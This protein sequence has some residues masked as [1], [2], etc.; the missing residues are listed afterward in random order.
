LRERSTLLRLLAVVAAFALVGALAACGDDDDDSDDSAASGDTT[1]SGELRE[2]DYMLPYQDSMSFLGLM[3][4][5]DEGGCLEQDGIELNTLPSEGSDF[6]AQQLIAGNVDIGQTGADNILIA[7]ASGRELRGIAQVG[8]RGVFT[9][10]APEDSNVSSMEDLEG[11]KLGVTDLGGGEIPLVRAAIADAGL[12]EGEDVELVVV[13]PGGPAA[14]DAIDSGQIAAYA[15]ANNDIAG[16]IAVGLE[17]KVILTEEFQNVPTTEVTLTAENLEDEELR[18]TA[19]TIARCYRE[20][21]EFALENPE[22]ARE[23]SCRLVP[24]ECEDPD[25]TEAYLQ[26]VLDTLF[27]PEGAEHYT[28]HEP[29]EAFD[30][31]Q[32]SLA[33]D[34]I[35]QPQDL[36]EVF[37]DDYRE[38][39]NSD[40]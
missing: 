2:V 7:N 36:D 1:T 23:I 19:I 33:A 37:P 10:V 21:S 5:K 15:G 4:A 8:G 9:I 26:A 6:V 32:T 22:E 31:V 39:I 38:E 18:D 35:A 28:D 25:V 14:Y 20:G 24:E 30:L 27:V 12:T 40:G 3:V 13:G 29:K 16:M 34:D 17:P 11:E